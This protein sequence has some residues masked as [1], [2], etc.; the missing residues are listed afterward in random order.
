MKL[1]LEVHANE[2]FIHEWG[3]KKILQEIQTS[4]F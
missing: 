1:R 4:D 3:S 2:M